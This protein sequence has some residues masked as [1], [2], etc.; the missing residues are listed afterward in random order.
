LNQQSAAILEAALLSNTTLRSI[1]LSEN[2]LGEEGMR[3]V[4]R[5]MATEKSSVGR[6]DMQGCGDAARP[7]PDYHCLAPLDFTGRFEADLGTVYGRAV[8][9]L[10]V[11]RGQRSGLP[12]GEVLQDVRID[13]KPAD[14][15][16]AIPS[17]GFLQCSARVPPLVAAEDPAGAVEQFRHMWAATL[18]SVREL[19]VQS[20][21]DCLVDER[22]QRALARALSVGF[23]FS[24]SFVQ[25]FSDEH[26][27]LQ[28]EVFGLLFPSIGAKP[29]LRLTGHT[30]VAA[31]RH[32]LFRKTL[33]PVLFYVSGNPTG[34]FSL[35]LDTPVG[36]NVAVC[37]STTNAWEEERRRVAGLPDVSQHGSGSH[38]RND[39]LDT[40][41][42]PTWVYTNEWIIPSTGTW[43]FDYVSTTRPPENAKP[44][45]SAQ[46]ERLM[47]AVASVRESLLPTMVAQSLRLISSRMYLTCEQLLTV[48]KSTELQD[49]VFLTFFPRLTDPYNLPQV[50]ASLESAA[51]E[52]LLKRLGPVPL[53][54]FF[55]VTDQAVEGSFAVHEERLLL[56]LVSSIATAEGLEC[57]IQGIND[58]ERVD[59][60]PP[61]GWDKTLAAF[62]KDG[63]GDG[64]DPTKFSRL[65][66]AFKADTATVKAAHRRTLA[67]TFGG[68]Q[69]GD[70]EWDQEQ[71]KFQSA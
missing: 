50:W 48:L 43:H 35:K 20:S 10:L 49:E 14:L 31:A 70:L 27:D 15:S 44:L 66:I 56:F 42:Y 38:F 3:S 67:T 25:R 12:L 61:A 57:D 39:T 18:K 5:G 62:P 71:G 16:T 53:F 45:P 47:V 33:Q 19:P 23:T 11:D 28:E 29:E 30:V 68:W 2:S 65:S 6:V 9:R 1:N 69:I 8:A 64:D 26:E 41:Q 58:K 7:G 54:G 36:Y 34:S 46:F 60:V 32:L 59:Y 4:L 52:S 51:Q 17:K 22:D 63:V 55:S 21:Y 37:V 13:N 24:R 40:V